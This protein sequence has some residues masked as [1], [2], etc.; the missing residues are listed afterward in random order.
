LRDSARVKL[1]QAPAARN[2]LTNASLSESTGVNLFYR[3][4][5]H[6]LGYDFSSRIGLR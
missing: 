3:S 1:R 4:P 6:A 5:A 2:R